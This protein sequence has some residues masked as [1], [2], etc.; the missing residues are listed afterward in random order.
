[1]ALELSKAAP[2]AKKL[3]REGD[4]QYFVKLV[5]VKVAEGQ[6][7]G[8]EESLIE[9]QKANSAFTSWLNNFKKTAKIQTNSSLTSVAQ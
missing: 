6:L 4:T 9:K 1:V 7:E 8:K 5:D 2:Y 3:V